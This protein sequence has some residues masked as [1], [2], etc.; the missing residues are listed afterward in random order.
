VNDIVLKTIH[1][2]HLYG[3]ANENSDR[4]NYIVYRSRMKPVQ[5]ISSDGQDRLEIGWPNFVE[6]CNRGVPQALEAM[7]SPKATIDAYPEFRAHYFAGGADVFDLFQRKIKSFFLDERDP[8]RYK[9]HSIRLALELRDLRSWG[10]FN[11]VLTPERLTTI[12]YIMHTPGLT[13]EGVYDLA[14]PSMFE[15]EQTD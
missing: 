4:D 8:V 9:K 7:F 14:T 5:T 15:K 3:T 1:G 13:L 11:P 2:S 6:Q 10:R 12:N